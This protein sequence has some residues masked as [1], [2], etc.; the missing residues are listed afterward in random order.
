M[1]S[2]ADGLKAQL[3]NITHRVRVHAPVEIDAELRS[4]LEPAYEAAG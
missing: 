1:A 4:W 2:V 3:G